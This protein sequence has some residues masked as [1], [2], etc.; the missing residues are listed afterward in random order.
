[1]GKIF[2]E[3]GR[4]YAGFPELSVEKNSAPR[5]RLVGGLIESDLPDVAEFTRGIINTDTYAKGVV[6]LLLTAKQLFITFVPNRMPEQLPARV[7][8]DELVEVSTEYL[9]QKGLDPKGI[10]I[11]VEMKLPNSSRECRWPN[12]W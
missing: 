11:V 8:D 12:D 6:E 2:P 4:H 1:M 3:N 10:Q 9:K 7:I 5:L